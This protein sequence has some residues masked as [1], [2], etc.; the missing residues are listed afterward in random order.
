MPKV[1][2][3]TASETVALDGLEVRLEHL[4][5]GYSV[6]FESHTADADLAGLFRG[7]PDDRCQLPRWG[8]VV[9]GKTSFRFADH[10]EIYEAG[11]AYYVPPGHIPVH[12]AGAEI[13]EFSPTE[14]LGATMSVVMKNIGR[15]A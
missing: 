9:K 2:R 6:C 4:E 12:H 8:Y 14:A 5:G 1:S 7:L 3:Q 13:I 11:D 15:G 10:E